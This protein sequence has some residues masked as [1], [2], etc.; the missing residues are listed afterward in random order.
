MAPSPPIQ[1]KPL[2]LLSRSPLLSSKTVYIT[3]QPDIIVP[4]HLYHNCLD[5]VH[6][7]ETPRARMV[8][9]AERQRVNASRCSLMF[10][11]PAFDAA[12]VRKSKPLKLRRWR[13]PRRPIVFCRE[14]GRFRRHTRVI[15]F[16]WFLWVRG[17]SERLAY[18]TAYDGKAIFVPLGN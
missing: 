8:T 1:P 16:S 12:Q 2:F 15:W 10:C 14:R 5:H 6:S 18:W 17:A 7:E 4:K 9:M 3:L 11:L 13:I